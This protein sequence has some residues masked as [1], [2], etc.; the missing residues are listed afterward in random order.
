MMRF[1]CLWC[2]WLF[3]VNATACVNPKCGH[4]FLAKDGPTPAPSKGGADA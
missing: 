1:I 3:P 4:H 2:G